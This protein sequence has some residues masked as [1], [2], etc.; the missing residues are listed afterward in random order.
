M[1]LHRVGEARA[2]EHLALSRMPRGKAGG[3]EL[4]EPSGFLGDVGG[5]RRDA[6]QY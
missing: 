5:N 1:H 2:D 4:G 6:V 3:A